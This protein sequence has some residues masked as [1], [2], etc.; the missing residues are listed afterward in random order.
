M[1]RVDKVIEMEIPEDEV[2]KHTHSGRNVW[3]Y[4]SGFLYPERYGYTFRESRDTVINM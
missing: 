3:L 1:G 4:R 2:I